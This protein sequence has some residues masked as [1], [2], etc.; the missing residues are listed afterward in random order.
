MK[1]TPRQFH[2]GQKMARR[3][4]MK[5]A[6]WS[7]IGLYGDDIPR[8]HRGSIDIPRLVEQLTHAVEA[9][10]FNDEGRGRQ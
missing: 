2:H 10:L 7:S 4:A 8:E 1:R 3:A 9:A 5:N 6:I